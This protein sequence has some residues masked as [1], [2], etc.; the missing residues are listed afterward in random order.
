MKKPV[1]RLYKMV[2]GGSYGDLNYANVN[3]YNSFVK[4]KEGAQSNADMIGTGV[5]SAASAFGP[6]GKAVGSLVGFQHTAQKAVDG[7]ADD[8][9]GLQ[10]TGVG[11]AAIVGAGNSISPTSS[12]LKGVRDLKDPNL[13]I[14]YKALNFIPALSGITQGHLASQ[15][16]DQLQHQRRVTEYNNLLDNSKLKGANYPMQ[17]FDNSENY[18]NGGH[19][20]KMF[21]GGQVAD[22]NAKVNY[23]QGTEDNNAL[24]AGTG[25]AGIGAI[26]V[27]G[28]IWS[29][30]AKGGMAASS[31]VKGDG[32]S[33]NRDI[34]SNFINPFNQ[35]QNN[36]NAG[37]WAKAFLNPV[38]S[39]FEKGR[40]QKHDYDVKQGQFRQQQYN[41][42]LDSSKLKGMN[43]S[44]KG[45]DNAE[46]YKNG[47]SLRKMVMGGGGNDP[48]PKFSYGERQ[49]LNN[50][51]VNGN[52]DKDVYHKLIGYTPK[53]INPVAGSKEWEYENNAYNDSVNKFNSIDPTQRQ[54]PDF[55]GFKSTNDTNALNGTINRSKTNP[56]LDQ[57]LSNTNEFAMGGKVGTTRHLEDDMSGD[58]DYEKDKK[59]NLSKL[60]SENAEVE[61]NSH[62]NG[63]VKFPEAGVELEG[64][65]T[66]NND[67]VFSKELGFAQKHKPIAKSIGRLEQKPQTTIVKNTLARMK[68]QEEQLK[69]TQEQTKQLL[70][71]D[72]DLDNKA[73]GGRLYKKMFDGGKFLPNVNEEEESKFNFLSPADKL[74]GNNDFSENYANING[75]GT[76][77]VNNYFG[78]TIDSPSTKS[79]FNWQ[80][81]GQS[82]VPFTDNLYNY[83]Q[84]RQRAKQTI[85]QEAT[86]NYLNPNL[87]N[88]SASRAE[89]D[90]Q[91][92][93][94]NTAV[95]QSTSNAASANST[96]ASGLATTIAAKNQINQ[97]EANANAEIKN[98]TQVFN[99]NIQKENNRT[100]LNNQLRILGA[101]DD[102]RRED[103]TNVANATN[104]ASRMIDRN[105]DMKVEDMQQKIDLSSVDPKTL[106]LIL[107]KNP[108][109][110]KQ[111]SEKKMGG[112]LRKKLAY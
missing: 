91:R 22:P 63:G 6:W 59:G 52:Y 61:G 97:E 103:S 93:N 87:V 70:G 2:V 14:G 25:T 30:V 12:M 102:I 67:F 17:G 45:Y 8:K 74:A 11:N 46:N 106:A 10:K 109:L 64:G 60:S 84:N 26:P 23:G 99:S 49:L 18:K 5:S 47:G 104:K 65:E 101:K 40:N 28:G 107:K 39:A 19:L 77:G 88:Y 43:Y 95:N 54:L 57:Y 83:F 36:N 7:M 50:Y 78:K 29:A 62:A 108:D 76:D 75:K 55:N 85:P 58:P 69:V 56:K 98:N 33:Q 79:K 112:S 44:M 66:I 35:F 3:D 92:L 15:A 72:S 111:L 90:R 89:A 16:R 42:L 53:Y 51:K 31:A 105:H 32:S 4:N 71:I 86:V 9:D 21:V 48:L 41:Q 81:A 73:M 34:G 27:V 100:T 110:A 20:N 13:G 96:R 82:V 37:D 94:F 38:G 68:E 24:I 80:Q 1:R